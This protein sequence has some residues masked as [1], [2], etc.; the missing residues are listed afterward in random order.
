MDGCKTWVW[1]TNFHCYCKWLLVLNLLCSGPVRASNSSVQQRLPTL[2]SCSSTK[3]S[4]VPFD[5]QR[6][7]PAANHHSQP[8]TTIYFMCIRRQ[9]SSWPVATE[10][11]LTIASCT[12]YRRPAHDD[13]DGLIGSNRIEMRPSREMRLFGSQA[14]YTTSLWLSVTIIT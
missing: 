10:S 5:L 7:G 3:T 1:R 8:A 4:L 9:S 14:L 12:T 2:H 6:P 11:S 13:M